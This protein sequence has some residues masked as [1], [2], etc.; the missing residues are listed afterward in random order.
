VGT[1]KRATEL[2][3]H[4]ARFGDRERTPEQALSE[5]LSLDELGDVVGTLG[6]MADVEDLHDP[7]VADARQHLGLALEALHPGTVLGPPGL[8]HLDR[9]HPSEASVQASINATKG[10]F[11]DHGV[12]LVAT[13]ESATGEIRCPQHPHE[14]FVPASER[15]PSSR[16]E[17]TAARG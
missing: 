9:D 13:V 3:G 15:A 17:V 6:G 1:G 14:Y 12:K 7:G 4:G 5:A 10:A 8:D 11:A 16:F 2:P